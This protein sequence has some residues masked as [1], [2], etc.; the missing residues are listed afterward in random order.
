MAPTDEKIQERIETIES[1]LINTVRDTNDSNHTT[2]ETTVITG[3]SSSISHTVIK[4]N[5][6]DDVDVEEQRK[7]Q[8]RCI[9]EDS[10][11]NYP[12][13][14]PLLSV[15]KSLTFIFTI[16]SCIFWHTLKHSSS[17]ST[18]SINTSSNSCTQSL[19]PI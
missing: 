3:S 6:N 16:S 8:L 11:T 18:Y 19:R 7:E 15:T 12:R 14:R 17:T 2:T 13:V 5:D 9:I 4:K 1:V 10:L